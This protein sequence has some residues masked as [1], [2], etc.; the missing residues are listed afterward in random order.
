MPSMSILLVE[1]FWPELQDLPE[2][3]IIH[4]T[5][6]ISAGVLIGGMESG[7]TSIA[8]RIDLPNGQILIQETSLALLDGLVKAAKGREEFLE[9]QARDAAK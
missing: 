1:P 4:S 6:S 3:Q 8:L 5:E 2:G 9:T 7:E